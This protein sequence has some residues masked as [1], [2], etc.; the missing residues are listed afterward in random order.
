MKLIDRRDLTRTAI[1]L[2]GTAAG[3]ACLAPAHAQEAEA[4][5]AEQG[6]RFPLGTNIAG[7]HD[8]STEISFVDVFKQ[9]RPWFSGS[10]TQPQ[11][12]R[13][14]D[15]D[16]RGWVRSL[17]PG[18]QARTLLYGHQSMRGRYPGGRYTVTYDGEGAIAYPSSI[19]VVESGPGRQVIDVDNNGMFALYVTATGS[20]TNPRNYIRN[21]SIRMSGTFAPGVLF[22]PPFLDNIRPHRAIRTMNWVYGQV[23]QRFAHAT[24]SE[25][26]RLDDARWTV[27]GAPIEAIASLCS[28]LG[29]DCWFNVNH[30]ADDDY[31]AKTAQLMAERLDPRLRLYLEW[32]NEVFNYIYPVH[33]VAAERGL[34][35]GLSSDPNVAR[36][37][38]QARR[39]KEVFRIW[40]EYFPRARTVRVLSG[41][42]GNPWVLQQALGFEDTPAHVDVLSIAPYFSVR[43]PHLPRVVGMNVDQLFAELESVSLP[44]ARMTMQW[45]A[46]LARQFNKPLVAYEGG[47]HLVTSGPYA[48]D[49]VMDA[50]FDA[51][52]RDPRMG[53]LYTRYLNDW[54]TTAPGSLLMHL[55]SCAPMNRDG[56]GRFGAVEYLG[57]PRSQA[58][59][60]DALMRW[61]EGA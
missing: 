59:K 23:N 41:Q 17:L 11:D 16:E 54:N 28:T 12:N 32:S 8:W 37:R 30:L 56:A 35:L 21:V 45:H 2:A 25:R 7:T 44:E 39:S 61:I 53:T 36:L 9:S 27:R 46:D 24:W 49:G 1:A 13:P 60:Y 40:N 31:V 20:S 33:H 5:P 50:L 3:L 14:L 19:R 29:R 6:A 48:Q 18:Q 43:T 22:Y 26:P 38:Y 58:P 15:L 42:A 47:Q 51:A 55:T 4:A 52:N 57:Q 34:S 10:A